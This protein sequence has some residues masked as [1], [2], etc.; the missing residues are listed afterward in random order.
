[1]IVNEVLLGFKSNEQHQNIIRYLF[2]LPLIKRFCRDYFCQPGWCKNNTNF[3]PQFE[4]ASYG[5][6]TEA[7][8]GAL[9]LYF[10]S[11]GT[12]L[13]SPMKG[14]H[15]SFKPVVET[16]HIWFLSIWKRDHRELW[17]LMLLTQRNWPCAFL[18]YLYHILSTDFYKKR[19]KYTWKNYEYRWYNI[20]EQLVPAVRE[21][22][23]CES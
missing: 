6:A 3:N 17:P 23:S 12:L 11:R 1:M 16:V 15:A 9:L 10:R 18:E 5:W 21:S 14:N 7:K 20:V 22:W 13:S 8:V 4:L 2:I 19:C